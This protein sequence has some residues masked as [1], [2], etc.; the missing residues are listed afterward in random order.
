MVN[1]LV[2]ISS[3]IGV[4]LA[5]YC[6]GC[7]CAYGNGT[8][9][10]WQPQNYTMNFTNQLMSQTAVNPYDLSCN[11]YENSTCQT[12]PPQGADGVC[13][14]RYTESSCTR[15]AMETFPNTT[16][17]EAANFTV[18]HIGKCGLCSTTQDL[19]VYMNIF[20]M[21]TVGKK[22]A[23]KSIV[24]TNWGINCFKDLGMTT[25][26]ARIWTY[27]A[28]W[29]SKKCGWICTKE[30]LKPFNGP[31]PFCEI[32]D[33]L[34]C[35]EDEAG[36]IFKEFGGRT[37]RRSGLASAITRPC[38]TVAQIDHVICPFK[39]YRPNMEKMVRK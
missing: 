37:R 23:I 11:P 25:P 34:Q 1:I 14:I 29:D 20:D 13:A 7:W 2:V 5:Q 32:N 28:I 15:Y 38:D 17:A 10:T 9:P 27:D 12:T 16:A 8:C 31:P 3:L 21:T 24:N 4:A 26:C 35:D 22:C 30:L 36:P 6:G 19:A 18:T 39:G 33:C